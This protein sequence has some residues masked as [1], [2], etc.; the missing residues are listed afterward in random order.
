MKAFLV[1]RGIVV[2][3]AFVSTWAWIAMVLRRRYDASLPPLPGWLW[4][5]G[6]VLV[7]VGG[8]LA[9]SCVVVFIGRGRGTPAPFD[10]PRAFVATGPYRFVRNPMYIGAIAVLEGAAMIF[11]SP[12]IAILGVVYWILAHALVLLYEERT[13]RTRFGESYALYRSRV[14]RWLP[15]LRPGG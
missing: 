13:L 10:P 14:R 5:L 15:R 4:P 12:S 3:T 11:R 1:F 6:V 2:S 8:L 9:L 7:V